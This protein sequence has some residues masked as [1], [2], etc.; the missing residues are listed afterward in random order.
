MHYF[1]LFNRTYKLLFLPLTVFFLKYKIEKSVINLFLL[2]IVYIYTDIFST[3]YILFIY[4]SGLENLR[5]STN[6]PLNYTRDVVFPFSFS[7]QK[8]GS[9]ILTTGVI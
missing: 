1:L 9:N 6:S 2:S 5:T 4:M 3:L 7:E 8:G